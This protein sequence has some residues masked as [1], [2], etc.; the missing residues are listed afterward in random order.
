MARVSSWE[1]GEVL[2]EV[3]GDSLEEVRLPG[4]FLLTADLRTVNARGAQLERANLCRSDLRYCCLDAA[5]L[6][7]ADLSM[8]R[9]AHGSFR[10]AS[11]VDARMIGALVGEAPTVDGRRLPRRCPDHRQRV[12]ILKNQASRRASLRRRSVSTAC[13]APSRRLVDGARGF[14]PRGALRALG[15]Q[16]LPNGVRRDPWLPGAAPHD[17]VAVV[18]W[19]VHARP[20]RGRSPDQKICAQ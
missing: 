7:G 18:E 15:G 6:D 11:L 3:A 8:S 17:R 9:V 5:L 13:T 12:R 19:R 10:G 1:T 20:A 2:L 4:A 14:A 16:R